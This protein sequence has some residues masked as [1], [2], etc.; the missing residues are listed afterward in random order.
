MSFH[1]GLIGP[2]RLTACR[3]VI[4]PGCR[5]P[6]PRLVVV[7]GPQNTGCHM[8]I[9]IRIK[10]FPGGAEV[11]PVPAQVHLCNPD[12]DTFQRMAAHKP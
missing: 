11:M 7:A 2:C 4:A 10:G 8:Q 3:M 5:Y 1:Y 6:A 12:I 9:D